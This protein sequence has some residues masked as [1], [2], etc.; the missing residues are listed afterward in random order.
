M[1]L[2]S[3]RVLMDTSLFCPK[4][5]VLATYN[6]DSSDA[7]TSMQDS[8]SIQNTAASQLLEIGINLTDT[9]SSKDSSLPAYIRLSINLAEEILQRLDLYCEP[10]VI[11]QDNNQ[12]R[13]FVAFVERDR[14]LSF[15][16]IAQS[17]SYV[18]S[19]LSQNE[20]N[21]SIEASRYLS[22]LKHHL[23]HAEKSSKSRTAKEIQHSLMTG[24]KPW[25]SLDDKY[26]NKNWL[27]LGFGR[28]QQDLDG[29]ISFDSSFLGVM[30][31]LSKVKS[32]QFLAQLG[33]KVPRQVLVNNA[34]QAC[35]QARHLGF[36]VVLKSDVGAYGELV[37][38]DLRDCKEVSD[39][40][41]HLEENIRRSGAN[42]G[43][44]VESFVA[45]NVYR[46][47]VVNGQFFDAYNM[48]PAGIIGDGKHTV[49]E[50]VAIE[51]TNPKRGSK[52]D[53]T[54]TYIY[55]ELGAAE[56]LM[57]KKQNMSVDSVPDNDQVVRLTANSNWSR[58]GTYEKVTQLVHQDNQKLA[59]RI[60]T[61]FKIDLL[62]VDLITS[63]ISKSFIENDLTIIEVNHSPA[64]CGSHDNTMSRFDDTAQR[65]IERMLPNIAYG[66]VPVIMFKA[67]EKVNESE[68]LFADCLNKLGYSAGLINQQG[69]VI[70][71]Q[72]WA[73]PD[74]VDYVNPGLQLLRNNT[75]G[76]A[77]IE[78]S[79]EN[80]VNFG[81]GTGGCDIAVVLDCINEDIMTPVWPNGIQSSK[82]DHFLC[83]SA[84][85]A[86][87]ILVDSMDSIAI[88]K[89]CEPDKLFALLLINSIGLEQS[90]ESGCNQIKI[91]EQTDDG[92]LLDINYKNQQ[93]E[94][95]LNQPDIVDPL[96]YIAI[97][98]TLLVL[99]WEL[100]KILALLENN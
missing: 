83:H 26:H 12:K 42:H 29:A 57:L 71:G 11:T 33:F 90:L 24:D 37:H 21:K 55:L 77:I 43:I 82:V 75:I 16:V 58:G 61:A 5:C 40:F 32:Q 23:D 91:L 89:Q 69:M 3:V 22:I 67:A 17:T 8:K 92:V 20:H 18:M 60:A 86:N 35:Q 81:L 36:P 45:G 47:E 51:N 56:L 64:I 19:L 74:Q 6:L 54:A 98:A 94:K 76:A 93:F 7:N 10:A 30:T 38:A 4:P 96:P 65:I 27:Q 52:T 79:A 85:L 95:R 34:E 100:E 25:F 72:I 87:I 73:S 70:D 63:N 15:K 31:S 49:K 2:H 88:C 84:R 48:I 50:L 46:V 9:A 53:A 97:L 68:I 99:D 44:F 78:H 28:Q 14:M 59:E 1:S 39:A 62:G 80:L 41:Y 66:D 13:V